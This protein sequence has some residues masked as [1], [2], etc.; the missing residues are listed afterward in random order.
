MK[1][2]ARST[3]EWIASVMIAT[4]PVIRPATTLRPISAV[5]EKI[6]TAAARERVTVIAPATPRARGPRGRG[7][8]SRP[9][10]RRTA[11]PSCGRRPVRRRGR[12]AGRSRSRRRRAA[13]GR[14]S[15]CVVPS[16]RCSAPSGVTWAIT[17]TY[18]SLVPAGASRPSF[19]R[20]SPSVACSPAKRAVRTPGAPFSASDSMPESSAIAVRPVAAAAARA[21]ISALS[22]YVS[23]VSSG[24][25]SPSGSGSS[26]TA[27]QQALEL[28]ELMVVAGGQ[29]QPHRHHRR[30]PTAAA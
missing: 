12:T 5:L 1:L 17:Q 10:R 30:Y 23:P 20:F 4:E 13:P 15:R 19:A 28:A 27:P 3:P 18:F 16:N 29:E 21:L 11:R 8:R 26:S 9:C 2:A 25:G 14:P 6:E 24:D 22:A 7:G